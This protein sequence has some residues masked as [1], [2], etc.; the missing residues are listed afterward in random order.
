MKK[1]FFVSFLLI[2]FVSTIS[3]QVDARMLRY[4]DVSATHITFVY[5]G[6][7]WVVAKEGGL[8]YKLSSPKGDET[9]PRFSPDGKQ[10]AFSGN[11]DGNTD[12]YVIPS[13][14]GMPERITHHSMGD[15]ILDWYPDGKNLLYASSMYSGRQRFNQF[16][17]VSA[18]GGIA[19]QLP[20]VYGEFA[21]LS[22]DA[23]QI[24][25]TKRT[26]THRTWKRYRGGTAAD[27]W[28][29]DLKTY[30][31]EKITDNAAN[32]ELPMWHGNKIYYLSDDNKEQRFNIYVYDLDSKTS[33]QITKFNDY[34][35][36]YPSI[37]PKDIVFEAG[38][39][40]YLLNLSTEKTAKVNV[41]VVTDQLT[42]SP[43]IE[44][45]KDLIQNANPSP[46]GN[47]VVV[48]ARGE[49]F[50]VP[51]EHGPVINLTNTSGIAE[52]YPAWSP[53]GKH[54][55]YWSDA[56][57][58][59]ELHLMN[60]EKNSSEKVSSFGNGYR[61]N[62]YWS[63][64][65]EKIAFV[66][67]SMTIRVYDVKEKELQ[68]V[69]QG[70]YMMEG[71][72]RGFEPSWSSDSRWLAYSRSVDNQNRAIFI[73]DTKEGKSK[74]VTSGYYADNSPAFD[75]DG[76]YL[77]FVTNRELSPLYSDLDNTFIYPNTTQL[78]AASLRN[79][80]PS[81][82]APRNDVV[83]IKKEEKKKEKKDEK[84]KDDKEEKDEDKGILIDFD[85]FESRVVILPPK[86]GNIGNVS[87]VSGKVLFHRFP[88][89]GSSDKENPI[90]Y[91]DLEERE[92]K[93]IVDNA[94]WFTITA[95][96]KKALVRKSSTWAIV[97]IKP[98][99]KL[100]KPLRTDEM[101]MVVNPKAE[102]KQIF[103]DVW[104]IERDFF[105]DPNMHGVDWNAMKDHYGKLV[106]NAIT[107][108][109]V[110]YIIGELIA[111]LSASHTYRGGGDSEKP[112]RRN[113]GYLGVDW[114][115][116]KDMYKIAKIIK[117]ADWDVEVRSPLA[118]P[119]VN[120]TEGDY[121]LAVNGVKLN[122]D[123]DP[124]A[125][126]QGLGGKTVEL[127]LKDGK[128][129]TTKKVLVE[130]LSS[131]T[132]LRHLAWIESNRKKVEKASNGK[133]GYV[134]VRSTGRDGQTELIRQFIA[135]LDKPGVI[136]DE[137]FNSGGQIPDRFVEILNRKPLAFWAVRDGRNWQHPP[138]AVYGPKVMLIN[139]WSGSGGDAFPNYFKKLGLGPLIGK[140]TW[141]G[142]IG[143]S[144]APSLI[145]GGYFTVP[146]F[147]MY[148][149]DGEW[150][151]EGH[152]V[153]P[154]IEVDDDPT[155]MAKGN[156]PQL[157]KAIDYVLNE[158]KKNPPPTPMKQP[159][160]EK[161]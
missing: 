4:P 115:L 121:V 123:K 75:P 82:L 147:R 90:M 27:I 151:P 161:R 102:W 47:R 48:E 125:A 28:L 16:Y 10:I 96:G 2:L 43:R 79:D 97:D 52:R 78:A 134:Y 7:I 119:D 66:D 38:G 56:S 41:E 149:P 131:E 62:I 105:Y 157:E 69:D 138:A 34:D 92:E 143:I 85:G 14:G 128:A 58:E 40:L 8:A 18:K 46:D 73:F 108:T 99:Q 39:A 129:D 88:N 71:A 110:N 84:E 54:V 136:I 36:H 152:G 148:D 153:D 93:T 45:V 33:R 3:A 118:Q 150:F 132:R 60:M 83:E 135:Q 103:N 63:P 80:V 89:S 24:A 35:I 19:E 49:L 86:A 12:I 13:M 44:E 140:R 21:S 109:D 65:S 9:F 122:T 20:V 124:Y 145:D 95:D 113:V 117:G 137:R 70:L 1:T 23:K 111:E 159:K 29:F 130:L 133:V 32:D 22:G 146:T 72:L 6:D 26:R 76:K 50:S 37:G 107:R 74:Q 25:Y 114:K 57:G 51:A 101:E 154:D 158:L 17:K 142:L 81:P 5:A 144:G 98:S 94:N 141:G 59:Y 67:Q 91:Y 160:Y 139:G 15:R 77:Y 31:S 55:A 112:N 87:A 104:R 155:Q 120:V 61:Y 53:N 30:A 11:Y 64:N 127:T 106:D 126:F 156:D 100:D 116:E 42:L 68:K